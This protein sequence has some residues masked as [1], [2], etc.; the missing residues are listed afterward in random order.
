METK[1]VK[2]VPC[3]ISETTEYSA[4]SCTW[5]E[6]NT[7]PAYFDTKLVKIG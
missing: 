5:G 6:E 2:K 4:N 1:L 3:H 7:S